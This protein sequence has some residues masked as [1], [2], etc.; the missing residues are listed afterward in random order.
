MGCHC[1]PIFEVDFLASFSIT[2]KEV[3]IDFINFL[4]DLLGQKGALHDVSGYGRSDEVDKSEDSQGR[5]F[6][7]YKKPFCHGS[8]R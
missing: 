6:W 1:A 3:S 2:P 4:A 5:E 7:L 8:C